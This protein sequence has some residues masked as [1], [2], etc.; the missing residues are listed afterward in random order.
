MDDIMSNKVTDRNAWQDAIID[1]ATCAFIDC[2]DNEENPR[3]V[4]NHILAWHAQI[5]VDPR[6]SEPAQKLIQQ[7]RDESEK[8]IRELSQELEDAEAEGADGDNEVRKQ[9]KIIDDLRDQLAMRDAALDALI[10]TEKERA[11]ARTADSP[12]PCV[13]CILTKLKNSFKVKP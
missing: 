9:Y 7:G 8:R 11:K 6:V 4:L 12:V 3:A 1:A 10:V 13:A 5:A 2:A